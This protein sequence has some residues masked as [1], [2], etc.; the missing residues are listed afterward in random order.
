MENLCLFAGEQGEGEHFSWLSPFPGMEA[1][2]ASNGIL[3][4]QIQISFKPFSVEIS[5]TSR[6]RWPC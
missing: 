2:Q 5:N 3:N 1:L 4:A 6:I